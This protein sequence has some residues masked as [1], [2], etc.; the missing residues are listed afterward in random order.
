M[1]SANDVI[2]NTWR[3]ELCCC[4]LSCLPFLALFCLSPAGATARFAPAG[5]AASALG[6]FLA[7][8]PVTTPEEDFFG[9]EAAGATGLPSAVFFFFAGAFV[10]PASGG[11]LTGLGTAAGFLGDGA[12]TCLPL[13]AAAVGFFSST[14]SE[15]DSSAPS[16]SAASPS[17]SAR[18]RF[19]PL[20]LLSSSGATFCGEVEYTHHWKRD[21]ADR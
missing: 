19:L 4:Y 16:F 2:I 18:A 13:E 1:A 6:S 15:S 7:G 10:A 8:L 14:S 12:D 11:V 20:P 3:V 17:C 9:T 21:M 5:L